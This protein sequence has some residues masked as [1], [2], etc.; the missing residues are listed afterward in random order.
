MNIGKFTI[1]CIQGI[2][3]IAGCSAFGGDVPVHN[4]ATTVCADNEQLFRLQFTNSGQRSSTV[5]YRVFTESTGAVHAECSHC[6]NAPQSGGDDVQLCLPKDKCHT[7]VL[8]KYLGRWVSCYQ[9]WNEEEMVVSWGGEV[10][11]RNNAYL[12]DHV[13]FGEGCQKNMQSR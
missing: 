10:L 1:L 12:F 5:S 3:L 4:A 6:S 13:T 9:G 11:K 2:S 7:L 8:G